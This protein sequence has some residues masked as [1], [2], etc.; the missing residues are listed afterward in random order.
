MD[1]LYQND[2]GPQ[3]AI[4]VP[5]VHGPKLETTRYNRAAR[6]Q[7]TDARPHSLIV[8]PLWNNQSKP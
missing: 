8:I 4:T 7:P 2:L 3:V 6:M 5:R 1:S